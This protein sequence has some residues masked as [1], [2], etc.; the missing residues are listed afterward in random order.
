MSYVPF[1]P[2]QIVPQ[3]EFLKIR[4]EHDLLEE[5]HQTRDDVHSVRIVQQICRFLH[6]PVKLL[7]IRWD[8]SSLIPLECDQKFARQQV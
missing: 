7:F 4:Q 3:R 2:Y 6:E 8:F 1:F 5:C